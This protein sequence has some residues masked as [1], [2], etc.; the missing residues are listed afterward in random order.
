MI[1]KGL[2]AVPNEELG[3]ILC[4][5]CDGYGSIDIPDTDYSIHCHACNGKGKLDWCE[6]VLGPKDNNDE[7]FYMNLNTKATIYTSSTTSS[8]EKYIKEAVE[9]MSKKIDLEIV[10]RIINIQNKNKKG[11][12]Y[13]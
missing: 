1:V 7:L 8:G 13:F 10:D 3:E 5:E 12:Y 4:S 2:R 9:E 11:G 6:Q